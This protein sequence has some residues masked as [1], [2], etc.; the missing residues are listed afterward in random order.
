M[1]VR[2][3]RLS[4]DRARRLIENWEEMPASL[5]LPLGSLTFFRALL[6]GIGEAARAAAHPRVTALIGNIVGGREAQ[7]FAGLAGEA[8]LSAGAILQNAVSLTRAAEIASRCDTLW[9]DVTEVVRT[10]YGFPTEV[11]HADGVVDR[12]AADGFL[13]ADPFGNPAPFLADWLQSVAELSGSGLKTEVGV[14]LSPAFSSTMAARLHDMGF[15]R[16]SA[17]PARRDEL[18]LVLAQRV[19]E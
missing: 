12:Y 2:L 16:F 14:D 6:R 15:R 17:S 13:R 1:H 8:G 9:V 4:S 11:V 5:F 10:A 7:T 18:R 3:S 19:K